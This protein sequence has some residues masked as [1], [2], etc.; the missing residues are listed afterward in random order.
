MLVLLLIIVILG[1]IL[2]IISLNRDFSK[3]SS[4]V[5]VSTG[6]TEPDAPFKVTT[7]VT[8]TSW[9]PVSY[10]AVHENYPEWTTLPEDIVSYRNLH[11]I[12][13]KK[14]FRVGGRSKKHQEITVSISKRGVHMIKGDSIES[15]DFLG[16]REYKNTVYYR[17]EIVV[18]PRRVDD[19]GVTEALG[20]FLG[21]IQAKRWLIRD[22]VLTVGIREYTGREPMKEIHWM[23]SAHR[24]ELMVKEFDYNRELTISV[25]MCVEGIHPWLDTGMDELCELT[26]TVC[27]TMV[28]TGAMVNYFTN[29]RLRGKSS[30]RLWN[31]EVSSFTTKRLLEGLG[32]ATS[33]EC[34]TLEGLLDYAVN[35][36]GF[37]TAYV[38]ILP[39]GD[40]RGDLVT[41]V[42]RQHT[43]QEVLV[44]NARNHEEVEEDK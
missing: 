14:V 18:Y 9:M 22:P 38:V 15:G 27:E 41:Q 2:E 1:I 42:L 5:S 24:G 21:D 39:F 43:G 32:R 44:L 26:R 13:V 12:K 35:Q 34:G 3:I 37:D 30:A 7:T 11:D 29:C 25:L 10:L 8:N 33:Y 6:E 16:L 31:V 23:A 20:Q 4:S 19:D 36:N 17:E 40:N 28:A